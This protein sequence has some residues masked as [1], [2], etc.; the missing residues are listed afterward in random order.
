MYDCSTNL[1]ELIAVKMALYQKNL[2]LAARKQACSM[3]NYGIIILKW[4]PITYTRQHIVY[5]LCEIVL[6]VNI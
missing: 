6:S 5:H 3:S 1:D 2:T 4:A